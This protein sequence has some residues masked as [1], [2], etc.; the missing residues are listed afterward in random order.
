MASRLFLSVVEENNQDTHN[1]LLGSDAETR[2]RIYR[3]LV[4]EVATVGH[5]SEI[6]TTVQQQKA[7]GD[8]RFRR[9]MERMLGR[10][11]E[12]RPAHRPPGPTLINSL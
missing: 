3:A 5:L 12:V 11:M 6:R 4:A 7:L 10:C 9:Q 1:S 8:A 2:Q